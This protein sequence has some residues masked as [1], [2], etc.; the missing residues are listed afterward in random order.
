VPETPDGTTGAEKAGAET[1][2][3]PKSASPESGANG[4]EKGLE[5]RIHQLTGEI[6]RKDEKIGK[7][8]SRLKELE[9]KTK[10]DDD[11][12]IEQLAKERFGPQLERAKT[13]EQHLAT[14]R[15]NLLTLIPDEHKGLVLTGDHIPVEQQIA[16]A[17]SVLGLL[18][19]DLPQSFTSGSNP[20]KEAAKRDVPRA[21]YEKWSRLLHT[22]TKKY[23]EQRD[24]MLAAIREGRVK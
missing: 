9:E 13:L 24:D 7:L 10:T 21:E 23:N 8:E 3:P 18:K 4:S 22:D 11:R 20:P 16:Q 14:E 2:Q 15:D 1:A 19:K 5:A 6:G 17:R 12:R